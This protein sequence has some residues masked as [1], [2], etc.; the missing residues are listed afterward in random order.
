MTEKNLTASITV[1]KQQNM[2]LFQA[3]TL[4]VLTLVWIVFGCALCLG[5]STYIS[6]Y[7]LLIL[8]LS[9]MNLKVMFTREKAQTKVLN[10][11]AKLN[12]VLLFVWAIVT[13]V[14]VILK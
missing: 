9:L 1:K 2:K 7:A 3:V 10:I 14:S 13:I 8:P 12:G 6:R 4:T 5:N 11:L